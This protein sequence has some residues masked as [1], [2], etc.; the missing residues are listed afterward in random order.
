M[1]RAIGTI[2][3]T[4]NGITT[5][6]VVASAAETSYE[7]FKKAVLAQQ[8]ANNRAAGRPYFEA[9]PEGELGRVEGFKLRTAAAAD[10]AALLSAARAALTSPP[11]ISVG[12]SSAY[13]DYD[14]D[15]GLWERYYPGYYRDTQ[16]DRDALQGGPHGRAAVRLLAHYVGGRKAAPGFSNHSDGKAVDFYTIEGGVRYISDT[17]TVAQW[18]TTRFRQWLLAHASRHN[19]SPLAGEPWHW[20]HTG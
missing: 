3:G 18:M 7:D 13:R 19:C 4:P 2:C 1:T 10:C 17:D 11:S 20:N 12:L 15:A 16:S 9:V 14:Y 5:V 8:I 6:R